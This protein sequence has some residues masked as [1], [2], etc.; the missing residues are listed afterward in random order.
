M[1][2]TYLLSFFSGGDFLSQPWKRISPPLM[3][4]SLWTVSCSPTACLSLAH[5]GSRRSVRSLCLAHTA[6]AGFPHLF[7]NQ[8]SAFRLCCRAL[9]VVPCALTIAKTHRLWRK[10]NR[11]NSTGGELRTVRWRTT[12]GNSTDAGWGS[13]IGC[14]QF[15]F[16]THT[17]P[18]E[19]REGWAR[20]VGMNRT[21]TL[22]A[23]TSKLGKR[24]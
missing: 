13:T 21:G 19:K 9:L 22:L 7:K 11:R 12:T 3:F 5:D 24:V 16:P 2:L 14:L 18:T 23:H 8:S 4:V 20:C 17:T 15:V 10:I 1:W 6:A